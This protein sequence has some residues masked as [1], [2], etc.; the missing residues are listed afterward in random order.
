[1]SNRLEETRSLFNYGYSKEKINNQGG[2]SMILIR[3]KRE[4]M[5]H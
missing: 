3:E 1:M 4:K 2:K 5:K